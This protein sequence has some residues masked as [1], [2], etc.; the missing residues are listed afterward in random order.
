MDDPAA[1]IKRTPISE[2]TYDEAR[3]QLMNHYGRKT[4]IVINK[5][6]DKHMKGLTAELKR[7]LAP[8]VQFITLRRLEINYACESYKKYISDESKNSMQQSFR[9]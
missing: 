9:L 3:D 2:T 7:E 4:Q 1:I 8:L 6:T 5:S